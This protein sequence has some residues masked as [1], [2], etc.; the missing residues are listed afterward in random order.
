M[1]LFNRFTPVFVLLLTLA[2]LGAPRTLQAQQTWKGTV[3]GQSKDMARQAEAFLPNE[4]WIHV[5]DKIHWTFSSGDIHTV[6]FLLVG[7]PYPSNFSAG[8]PGF[9]ASGTPFDGTTCVSSTPSG[10][11]QTFDVTFAA[12]G[13]FELV[14]LVHPEMFGTIH[15]LNAAE[16]LPH[17]QAY[18]DAQAQSEQQA[19]LGDQDALV[20][21][22]HHHHSM[23]DMLSERV[24]HGPAQVVA[25]TGVI[26]ATPGGQESLSIVRFMDGI[27]EIHAGET[28]EWTNNDPIIGHTVTFGTEPTDLFD[29]SCGPAPGCQVALD[30]DGALHAFITGPG[31]NVHSGFIFAALE[32]YTGGLPVPQLPL[33]PPTRFRVNFTAPGTYNYFCSLHDNLGMVGKVI[34]L[35]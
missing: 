26:G 15:V 2:V 31:Q 19:L 5:G 13:N 16:T 17:D 29:P 11:G 3:G 22:A 33:F 20:G 4:F 7:Q 34:V 35:P 23:A 25:G 24:I 18:Y 14:C 12:A 21:E 6:S 1:R 27:V 9:S 8:C 30:P 10:T 32:G 28:V